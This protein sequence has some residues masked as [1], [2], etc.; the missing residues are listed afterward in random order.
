MRPGPARV[1]TFLAALA[2][3]SLCFL[4]R[5]AAASPYHLMDGQEDTASPL[6]NVTEGN[7]S[8]GQSF[9]PVAPFT[10]TRVSLYVQD[11]WT[12]RCPP[13]SPCPPGRR[14]GSSL[15]GS[16]VRGT[17]TRGG[18]RAPTST[19]GAA[20]RRLPGGAGRS[21]PGTSRSAS[22]GGPLRRSRR[23]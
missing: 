23:A 4:P 6:E 20:R 19:P 17:A 13:P 9:S 2:L 3:A 16:A 1:A 8:M 14:T 12:S 22:G 15:R 10:L 5:P 18:T 11:R 21:S 7:L